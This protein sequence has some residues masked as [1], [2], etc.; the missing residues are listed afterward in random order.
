MGRLLDRRAGEAVPPLQELALQGAREPRGAGELLAEHRLGVEP[1]AGRVDGVD[2]DSLAGGVQ[3][4]HELVDA[5]GGHVAVHRLDQRVVV[6][7]AVPVPFVLGRHVHREDLGVAVALGKVPGIRC[8][9]ALGGGLHARVEQGL[10]PVFLHQ[11]HAEH[12]EGRKQAEGEQQDDEPVANSEPEKGVS[13]G[14]LP[15]G[16]HE[17]CYLHWSNI[18]VVAATA[19]SP[20]APSGRPETRRS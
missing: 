2:G 14:G 6:G 20:R 16:P 12:G 1:L 18:V 13:P 19:P 11:Q 4:Q 8:V 3:D 9:S 17:R 10:D 5:R 7:R 15:Q